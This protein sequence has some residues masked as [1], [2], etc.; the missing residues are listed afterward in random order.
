MVSRR[1]V[2]SSSDMP[3]LIDPLMKASDETDEAI[4]KI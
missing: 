4:S 3:I 1:N 2:A